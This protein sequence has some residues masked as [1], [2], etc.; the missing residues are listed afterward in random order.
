MQKRAL[1]FLYNDYDLSYEQLLVKSG[2]DSM[3][4]NRLRSLCIEIYKTLNDLNPTIMNEIFCL[5]ETNQPV[6]EKNKLNLVN[7]NYNQVNFGR[8]SLRVFGP[9]IWNN[10]PYHIKSSKNLKSF[11]TMIR[12]GNGEFCTYIHT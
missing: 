5:K 1:R 12:F 2:K 9:K 3:N 4:V 10:L 8:K 11:K 6:C 7:P